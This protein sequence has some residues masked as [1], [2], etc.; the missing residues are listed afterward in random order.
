MSA[1]AAGILT[2]FLGRPKEGSYLSGGQLSYNCPRCREQ[3]HGEWDNKYNLDITFPGARGRPPLVASCWKCSLSV[4]TNQLLRLYA[5]A[6]LLQAWRSYEQTLPPGTRSVPRAV[7][8]AQLPE[9]FERVREHSQDPYMQ[10]AWFYLTAP[11]PEGRGLPPFLVQELGFGISRE[12]RWLNRVLLPSYDAEGELNY[13]IGRLLWDN[14][15]QQPPYATT[16]GVKRTDIIFNEH[17]LDWNQPVMLVEGIF[18]YAAYP[19]NTVPLLGKSLVP[20][21]PLE[22]RLRRYRPPVI[23]GIDM[24][25]VGPD[26]LALALREVARG[27]QERP[28]DVLRSRAAGDREALLQRLA[29]LGIEQ[30]YWL[31]LPRNDMG[32]L[33]QHDGYRAVP[34]LVA[35]AMRPD[36]PRLATW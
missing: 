14:D 15:P 33:L 7:R 20:G 11:G 19:Y 23:L 6:N 17:R 12:P 25:A 32:K 22:A 10:A 34:A 9:D 5:P 29:E 18:D 4:P 27:G 2:A 3:N 21:M 28:R 1:V 8:A 24:D 13:V 31:D 16:A 30:R 36:P 35:H 26:P